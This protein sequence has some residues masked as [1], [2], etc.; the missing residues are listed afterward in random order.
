MIDDPGRD[1]LNLERRR[2]YRRKQG[3][4][5]DGLPPAKATDV[6]LGRI[7]ID[8]VRRHQPRPA[9]RPPLPAQDVEDESGRS[10]K[11]LRSSDRAALRARDDQRPSFDDMH[12]PRPELDGDASHD[13]SEHNQGGKLN[14]SRVSESN[15]Y[16]RYLDPEDVEVLD[17]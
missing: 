12:L 17:D 13:Q 16:S 14:Q 9:G 5:G 15:R 6:M 10:K 1:R 11:S 2:N 7:P 8:K 3:Q 4:R